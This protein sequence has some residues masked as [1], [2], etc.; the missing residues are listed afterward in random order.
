MCL[1][2]L[3]FHSRTVLSSLPVARV[4]LSGLNATLRIQDVCPVSVCLGIP[5]LVSHRAEGPVLTSRGES[6]A[7]WN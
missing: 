2:V 7:I 3:A 5:V 6:F 1:P 4:R